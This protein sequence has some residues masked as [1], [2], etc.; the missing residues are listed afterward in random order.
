MSVYGRRNFTSKKV[1]DERKRQSAVF[2][3]KPVVA[4]GELGQAL[5]VNPTTGVLVVEIKGKEKTFM[6][7]AVSLASQ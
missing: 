3:G 5:R 6:P 4:G 2:V 7:E 1:L